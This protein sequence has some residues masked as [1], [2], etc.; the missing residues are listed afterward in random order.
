MSFL[1]GRVS[2]GG[3]KVPGGVVYTQGGR[4]TRGWYLAVGY[5]AIRYPGEGQGIHRG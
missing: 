5:A 2:K 1:G 3:G 4:Y